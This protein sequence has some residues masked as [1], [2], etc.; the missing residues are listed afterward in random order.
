MKKYLCHIV[1][2]I[3]V[4]LAVASLFQRYTGRVEI[5]LQAE[6]QALTDKVREVYELIYLRKALR[7]KTLASADDDLAKRREEE[8][9]VRE[10]DLQVAEKLKSV[11][12]S[13]QKTPSELVRIG[14]LPKFAE[15]LYVTGNYQEA[16]SYMNAGVVGLEELQSCFE[17]K[18]WVN[19]YVSY[20]ESALRCRD[21]TMYEQ[22]LAKAEILMKGIDD[23]KFCGEKEKMFADL[24]QLLDESRRSPEQ[25]FLPI[26]ESFEEGESIPEEELPTEEMSTSHAGAPNQPL[27]ETSSEN[28][29]LDSSATGAISPEY[30]DAKS[31]ESH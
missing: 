10:L 20:A 24:R 7:V 13:I 12:E 21:F 9:K 28:I 19:L 4:L 14:I 11:K 1:A 3:L 16:R 6:S 27:P 23:T 5:A 26:W 18:L 30:L 2:T 17:A 31:A 25:V 29:E 22:C 15:L 8:K